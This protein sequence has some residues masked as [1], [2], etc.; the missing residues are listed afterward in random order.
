MNE[1]KL[2]RAGLE[3]LLE[4]CRA[5]YQY[6]WSGDIDKMLSDWHDAGNALEAKAELVRYTLCDLVRS[7]V[8][9]YG[10]MPEA[11]LE[12]AVKVLEVLGWQVVDDE[13]AEHR[14]VDE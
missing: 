1:K 10:L 5:Y 3:K 7:M 13:S 14:A 8:Q 12:D 9:P 6:P 4:A 11:T 2:P